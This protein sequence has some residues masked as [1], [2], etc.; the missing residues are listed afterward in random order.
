MKLKL[1]YIVA[2]SLAVLAL[3][4]CSTTVSPDGTRTT[5]VDG[6]AVGAVV[7]ILADK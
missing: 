1:A 2:I 5:T 6:A 4:N 7:E 3:S